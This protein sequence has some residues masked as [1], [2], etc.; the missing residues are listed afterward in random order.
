LAVAD[1]NG[2]GLSDAVTT[3]SG[4]GDVQLFLGD[5]Q[6]SIRPL[7]RIAA[8]KSLR[9]VAAGH[10]NGDDITDLVTVDSETDE[11]VILL[12]SGCPR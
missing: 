5:R 11:V 2:D 6:G 8:G 12:A 10:F 9:G 4:S 7:T 3:G 1:F